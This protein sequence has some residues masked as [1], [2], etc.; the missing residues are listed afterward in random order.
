MSG[1]GKNGAQQAHGSYGGGIQEDGE[2]APCVRERAQACGEGATRYSISGVAIRAEHC[3]G[4]GARGQR[5]DIGRGGEGV[6]GAAVRWVNAVWNWLRRVF[7][8]SAAIERQVA[9]EIESEKT[10]DEQIAEALEK[11]EIRKALV[12]DREKQEGLQRTLVDRAPGEGEVRC[13]DGITRYVG[14]NP[15]ETIRPYIGSE[16]E[17]IDGTRPKMPMAKRATPREGYERMTCPRC[18]GIGCKE[19]ENGSKSVK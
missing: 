16:E 5:A 15:F 9:R 13:A 19:C 17:T 4:G 3:T 2:R 14:A 8:G 11:P 7:G 18:F 12:V 10:L 1:N 6:E